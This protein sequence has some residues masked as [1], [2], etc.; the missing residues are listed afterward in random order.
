M[1]LMSPILMTG[2]GGF[3]CCA[4]VLQWLAEQESV[5]IVLDKLTYTGSAYLG[6]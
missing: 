5:A 4:F 1:L 3:I 2:G 6:S